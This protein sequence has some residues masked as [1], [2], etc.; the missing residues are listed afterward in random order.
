MIRTGLVGQ[1]APKAC[2]VRTDGAAS[3]AAVKPMK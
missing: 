1:V 2:E 3:E